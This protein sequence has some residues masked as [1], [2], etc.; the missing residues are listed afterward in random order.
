MVFRHS[1]FAA[2]DISF[3]FPESVEQ[4]DLPDTGEE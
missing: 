1:G 4:I 3:D 2:N